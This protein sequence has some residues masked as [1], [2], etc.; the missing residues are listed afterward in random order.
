LASPFEQTEN[1]ILS[2]AKARAKH[3]PEIWYFEAVSGIGFI[4]ASDNICFF[5]ITP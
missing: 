3:Y 5:R 1:D 2:T 4:S